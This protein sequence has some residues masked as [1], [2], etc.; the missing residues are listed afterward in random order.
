MHHSLFSVSHLCVF[1]RITWNYRSYSVDR[2]GPYL[3]TALQ[4]MT[5]LVW[6]R[7]AMEIRLESYGPR[8]MSIVL[9]CN[10]VFVL[11][12]CTYIAIWCATMHNNK[13]HVHVPYDYIFLTQKTALL[14]KMHRFIKTKLASYTTHC[15]VFSINLVYANIGITKRYYRTCSWVC[16]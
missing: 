9:W 16:C 4:S 11:L 6:F 13:T 10:L 14:P 2:C 5:L 12:A 15:S 3:T 7:I 8:L 1:R